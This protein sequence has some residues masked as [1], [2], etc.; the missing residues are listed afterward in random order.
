[1][2]Y[3]KA[4][5]TQEDCHPKNATNVASCIMKFEDALLQMRLGKKITHPSFEKDVYFQACRVGL[6]FDKTPLEQRPM[7]IVKMKGECQHPDMGV[8]GGIDDMVYPGTLIIKDKFLDKPCKHGITPQL[9]LFLVM[10]DEWMVI[11]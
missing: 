10:S 4:N 6:I 3:L 7:S 2:A 9:C 11:E 1:M 5:P 8:G